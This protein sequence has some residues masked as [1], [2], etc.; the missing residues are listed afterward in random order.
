MLKYNIT[1]FPEKSTLKKNH[2]QK[3]YEETLDKI[4]VLYGGKNIVL[5]PYAKEPMQ[6][7]GGLQMLSMGF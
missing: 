5:G 7:E 1:Y 6:V 2:L 4:R 3:Y